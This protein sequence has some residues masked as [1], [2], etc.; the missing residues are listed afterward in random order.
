M[1]RVNTKFKQRQHLKNACNQRQ[2]SK[3]QNKNV[4]S[5]SDNNNGT[6]I[7]ASLLSNIEVDNDMIMLSRSLSNMEVDDIASSQLSNVEQFYQPQYLKTWETLLNILINTDNKEFSLGVSLLKLMRYNKGPNTGKIFS[8]YL[9]QKAYNFIENSLYRP[10]NSRITCRKP[11]TRKIKK[12]EISLYI[13]ELETRSAA[14][15]T[16][17]VTNKQLKLAIRDRLM[18]NKNQYS[19]KAVL[20][21]TQICEIGEM[22]YRSAE[23]CTKKIVEWLIGEEP[24]KW[25]SASTLVGWHKDVSNIHIIQQSKLRL[26][27]V[28]QISL[29][30]EDLAVQRRNKR[31]FDEQDNEKQ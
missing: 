27:G 2:F 13:I 28:K 23:T 21:A 16:P 22:S 4:A 5:I 26:S 15:K 1:P 10:S 11:S 24:D 7:P 30:D 20:I 31:K 14:C 25:F 19:S 8:K 9:Q 12:K 17:T 6:T 18:K 3:K 29:S